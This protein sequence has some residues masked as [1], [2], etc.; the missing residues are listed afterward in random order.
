MPRRRSSR[1]RTIVRKGYWRQSRS[2]RR[3]YVK[4]ARITDRG[5][6][7]KGPKLLPK[8]KKGK[9]EQF[10]Y[11]LHESAPR[12]HAAMRRSARRVGYAKT[13]Q[14]VNALNVL[15]KREKEGAKPRADVRWLK[16]H[17]AELGSKTARRRSRRSRRY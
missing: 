3:T 4:P 5:K 6:P 14:R 7:G 17:A 11:D 9:M 12:R 8:L 2:G 1:R 13:M 16:A 15:M 10:G